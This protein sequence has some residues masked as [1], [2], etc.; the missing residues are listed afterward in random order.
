MFQ[1]G[2]ALFMFSCQFHFGKEIHEISML[3]NRNGECSVFKN[4]S[5]DLMGEVYA[6]GF[7][8]LL[9]FIQQR[10]NVNTHFFIY[11]ETKGGR[12]FKYLINDW[13]FLT[14]MYDNCQKS[15]NKFKTNS[16]EFSVSQCIFRNV[17][18]ERLFRKKN[19]YCVT[20]KT[21]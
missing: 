14:T 19:V 16:T 5:T 2:V 17:T 11:K 4:Y 15:L 7:C 13:K 20:I 10:I 9:I 6:C 1:F 3:H 18:L 21:N 12:A 8:K